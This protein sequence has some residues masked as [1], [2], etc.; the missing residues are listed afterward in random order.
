V[1]SVAVAAGLPPNRPNEHNNF[2]LLDQPVDSGQSQPVS[3]WSY[4]SADFFAS[5]GIP[6]LE[7][8]LFDE[9][10]DTD[11]PSVLV[12]SQSWSNRY[13]PDG[14]AVGK[15]LLSGGCTTCDPT[16][17]VGIV[18]DVKYQGLAGGGDAMYQP[19]YQYWLGAMSVVVK[20]EAPTSA[21]LAELRGRLRALD[22]DLPLDNAATMN[23]RIYVSMAQPRHW[24]TLLSSFAVAALILSAVGIFGVLSY[25]VRRQT[26]EIGVRMALGAQ[27]RDVLLLILRQGS[28]LTFA[29]LLI[30]TAAALGLT[31]FLDGLLYG[32][33]PHDPVTFAGVAVLLGAV[34]LFAAW[35][36]A[37][38]A[39]RIDPQIALR[40]D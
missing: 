40:Q 35:V 8:R 21:T 1:V 3:P 11:G 7:G 14:S 6:L 15:Q 38:R 2:D 16:T 28:L 27:R 13:Y 17:V 26:R 12:V 33:A 25:S 22:P 5:L 30:G 20:T 37:R 36:P 39:S 32:V 29:G 34:A 18:G 19:S 23:E 24:A 4:V 31:R 9:S 10:I